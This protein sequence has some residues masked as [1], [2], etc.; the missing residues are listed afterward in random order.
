MSHYIHVDKS[1]LN[2]V[3]PIVPSDEESSEE[4]DEGL[5]AH[6]STKISV[7]FICQNVK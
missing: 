3:E 4:E 7:S 6:F 1:E 2:N 5:D